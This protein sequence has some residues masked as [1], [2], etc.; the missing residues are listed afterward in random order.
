MRDKK[1]EIDIKTMNDFLEFWG[2]FHSIYSGMLEK[3]IIT[4][5]DEDKFMET[6]TMIRSKYNDL[7]SSLEYRYMPHGRLT[8][9]VSDI[10]AVQTIRFISE[11]NLR[12]VDNDWKDSYIFLNNIFERLKTRKRRFK[13][14]S[15]LGVFFK[16]IREKAKGAL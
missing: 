14:F 11:E 8:D 9:P 15:A 7:A 16:R 10:L 6:K 12:K 5:E 3:G 4:K 1:T 13:E 2:K